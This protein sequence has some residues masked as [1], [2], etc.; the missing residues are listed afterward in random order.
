DPKWTNAH[1]DRVT[2]MVERDKNHPSIIVWSM[3]NE[4]GDG[5]CFTEAF[6]AIKKLD[7]SRPIHYERAI[8]G[9][10]TEI[11]AEM[12]PSTEDLKEYTKKWQPKTFI[13]CEYSHAMGN[14]NGN[15]MDMWDVIYDRNNKQL[16]GGFI[17]DWV[18]QGLLVKNDKGEEYIAYGGDFGENM[19]SD[20]NFLLN[21]LVDSDRTPHPATV[22]VKYAYAYVRFFPENLAENKIKVVN[23]HDFIDLSDYTISWELVCEGN[24]VQK[25]TLQHLNVAPHKSELVTLPIKREK[26]T[27]NGEY[28]LNLSVKLNKNRLLLKEGDEVASEQF[29]YENTKVVK[30]ENSPENTLR[31]YE[32][33]NF[34]EIS[35]NDFKIV[36]DTEKGII[37]SYKLQGEEVL[38]NGGNINFWRA[39]N[40]NDLRSNILQ[41][42][43]I[44]RKV[45][46]SARPMTYTVEQLPKETVVSFVFNHRDVAARQ[47]INYTVK[48]DG[49]IA[50]K[51]ELKT[52]RF[53]KLK[54]ENSDKLSGKIKLM[55]NRFETIVLNDSVVPRIGLR[56]EMS[57]QFQQLKFYGRGPHENYSDRNRSAFV[58][59]YESTVD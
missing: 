10:N 39:P 53:E 57:K 12:Y 26:M 50:V 24:T 9:E 51:N 54:R 48:A 34:C 27:K 14:S 59:I 33:D 22:E 4:A 58:G 56:F 8:M 16:Q 17:W 42:L 46:E 52:S 32:V 25:G 45:S 2:R 55:P 38:A 35:S 11:F 41:R 18:D 28:F 7:T 44:W 30:A 1:V 29:A 23:Y 5:V 40:D 31:T 49:S 21:G 13:M 19:P 6:K 15:L 43:G 47:T 3:G 36:F 37:D 20:E